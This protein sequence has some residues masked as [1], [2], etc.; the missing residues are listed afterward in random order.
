MNT[1]IEQ[2][3]A[4]LAGKADCALV[5]D[6]LN[7]RYLTGMKSSAGYVL[8]FPEE[9]YLIIDSRYIERA[10][11]VVKDCIVLEQEPQVLRQLGDLMHRHGAGTCALE[12]MTLTLQRAA[13]FT[14]IE[15]V[16][17]LTN[18]LLSQAL[19]DLRTVK[20]AEELAKIEAAQQ[21]AEDALDALLQ[22]LHAGMT[23]RDVAF[24]LDFHMRRH[25]AEDLSYAFAHSC[26]TAF[27]K[28][29]L[30]LG[31]DRLT[32][33]AESLLFGSALPSPLNTSKSRCHLVG[34]AGDQELVQTAF[35][36][37]KT[38]VTPYHMA[39]IVSAIAND[40]A[41]M[42][43]YLI[44]HVENEA[45]KV[46]KKTRPRRSVQLC[47]GS[48]AAALKTLMSA[49]VTDGS[50]RALSGRGYEVAGK[51]GSAEYTKGDGSMGTHSWFVGFS[52]G[53]DPDLVICVLAENGGAG[54]S[55]AVPIAGEVLDRY[56]SGIHE[57][58][59]MRKEEEE[60]PETES[61][62]SPEEE[63]WI[64]S[65]DADEDGDGTDVG[66]A[67]ESPAYDDTDDWFEETPSADPEIGEEF[68]DG[69]E[70]G[71]IEEPG[72]DWFDAA[73]DEWVGTADA[74]G[75]EE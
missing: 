60:N 2:L 23:E 3:N 17:M 4:L 26:N 44:D 49:V 7:R 66:E 72:E 39:L 16:E 70:G 21:L 30:D 47:T 15:G 55:T 58:D 59:E 65:R 63:E 32:A 56:Y 75:E 11:E 12:S 54:S 6:D 25:G 19:Y 53:N 36:Q 13:L 52:G 68:D 40:G 61:V 38:L 29:G 43:P 69:Q 74:D 37:G 10:R 33:T 1:R 45:G 34:T 51:T 42:K 50:A 46:I 22:K 41:V 57:E 5:T 20:S 18:S 24:E 9:A 31:A 28:I 71:W 35:G 67:V 73:G 64:G 48:E 27:S 8:V 14:R 62:N